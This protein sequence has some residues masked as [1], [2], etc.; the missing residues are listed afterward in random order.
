MSK[1]TDPHLTRADFAAWTK[2]F[3]EWRKAADDRHEEQRKD[4]NVALARISQLEN[5]KTH[6]QTTSASP[7]TVATDADLTGERGDPKVERNPPRWDGDDMTGRRWS[8]TSTAF[9][10]CMAGFLDWKAD[11]P[12]DGKE[13]YVKFDRL[14][15]RRSL[16]TQ[17][18]D[19][20]RQA[21]N[22][23][24]SFLGKVIARAGCI[25]RLAYVLDDNWALAGYQLSNRRVI[26]RYPAAAHV[27]IG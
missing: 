18:D 13:Q 14:D 20:M 21:D 8:Q 27:V 7:S 24:E 1:N 17:I 25:A 15:A 16:M 22:Q 5:R 9:L 4:L 19:Q 2:K 6:P 23:P 26:T 12:R 3:S 11:N 10:E